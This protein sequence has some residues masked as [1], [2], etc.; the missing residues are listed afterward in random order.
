MDQYE[1]Q[2]NFSQLQFLQHHDLKNVFNSYI[3]KKFFHQSFLDIDMIY[4][5]T[6]ICVGLFTIWTWSVKIS[7]KHFCDTFKTS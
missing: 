7:E 1:N 2:H 5:N 3:S 6:D 4:Q